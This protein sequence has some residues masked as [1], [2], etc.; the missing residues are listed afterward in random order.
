MTKSELTRFF[1]QGQQKIADD[2]ASRKSA[3]S[4]VSKAGSNLSKTRFDKRIEEEV[5][6]AD[7]VMEKVEEKPLEEEVPEMEYQSDPERY[8]DEFNDE[9]GDELSQAPTETLAREYKL[10]LAEYD[11]ERDIRK[12]LEEEVANLKS[13]E[14]EAPETKKEE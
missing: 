10:L 8:V 2:V 14:K 11:Q 3:M 9:Y 4:R 13:A 1:A 6:K 7:S 5:T 12:K